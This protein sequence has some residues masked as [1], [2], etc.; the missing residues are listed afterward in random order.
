MRFNSVTKAKLDQALHTI[1]F[2][3]G[4]VVG[5]QIRRTD[6]VGTEAAFHSLKEY[7]E[8]T[9][10]W[11]KVEEKRQGKTL[12]RRIFIASDDPTAVPEAKTK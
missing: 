7:M 4:P 8:W 6:K 3:K 2:S 5:L 11:F 12:T 10:I 1:P 9:E